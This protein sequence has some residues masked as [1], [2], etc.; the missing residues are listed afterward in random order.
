[1]FCVPEHS[2]VH[3]IEVADGLARE[4]TFISN[5]GPL[6]AFWGEWVPSA[7]YKKKES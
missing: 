3:G 2:G 5:F 6:R 7:Y 1:M 4:V